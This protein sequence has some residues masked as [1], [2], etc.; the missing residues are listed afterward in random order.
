MIMGVR[1]LTEKRRRSKRD[2]SENFP[3]S[4]KVVQTREGSTAFF[5]QKVTIM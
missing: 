5:K 3:V 1:V 4:I 2:P